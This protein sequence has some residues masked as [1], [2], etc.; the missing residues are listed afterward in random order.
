MKNLWRFMILVSFLPLTSWAWGLRGHAQIC[1]AAVYLLQNRELKNFLL[2]RAHMMSHLCNIPDTY[3]KSLSGSVRKLGDPTH[4]IDPEV[5]GI[6]LDKMPLSWKDLNKRFLKKPNQWDKDQTLYDL[7]QNLGS[8]LWRIEQFQRLSAEAWKSAWTIEKKESSHATQK[9]HRAS[10]TSSESTKPERFSPQ[11]DEH[12]WVQAVYQAIVYAGL[13]GHFV[14]DAAQPFHTTADFDGYRVGH[15]GIH[16]YYEE[17]LVAHLSPDWVARIVTR[18][19][20]LREQWLKDK[21]SPLKASTVLEGSRRFLYL[22]HAE[23]PTVLERD[24]CLEPSQEK[25]DQGM[26][27]RVKAK[28]PPAIEAVKKWEDLLVKHMAYATVYLAYLWDEAFRP[29]SEL[30]LETYRSFRYPHTVDFVAPDY[31]VETQ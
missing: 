30:S 9:S 16:A 26:K 31:L 3:W 7:N 28:R 25:D 27:I 22:S 12:P 19:E 4:Y 1:E 14:G 21:N 2:P 18:A 29:S 20:S 13:Q 17:E 6:P 8:V 15:G 5:L 24:E 23:I 11:G 10:K